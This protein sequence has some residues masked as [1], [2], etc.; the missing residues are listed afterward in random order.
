QPAV[1]VN[2]CT[3][4]PFIQQLGCE[5][6]VLGPGSINQAHQP[7]EFLA[8]EKIKPSQAIISDMIKASCFSE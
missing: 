7:D 4:A 8:M 6:I 3:E 5:T 2:Y 1:A